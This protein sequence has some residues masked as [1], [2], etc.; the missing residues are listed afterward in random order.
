LDH[1]ENCRPAIFAAN[2]NAGGQNG[3]P[4]KFSSKGCLLMGWAGLE[5]AANALKGRCS[6]I[7]LP[8][9]LLLFSLFSS[10]PAT[11]PRVF[12]AALPL[13]PTPRAREIF[14]PVRTLLQE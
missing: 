14:N 5:P 8:T 2:R 13:L 12:G 1:T 9:Q 7:E 4:T 6:T 3:R 10:S 11:T